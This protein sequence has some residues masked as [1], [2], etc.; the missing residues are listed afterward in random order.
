MDSFVARS[1]NK[2]MYEHAKSI[3]CPSELW[4]RSLDS[5]INPCNYHYWGEAKYST[6]LGSST[7]SSFHETPRQDVLIRFETQ[8][9]WSS[10]LGG[11][12]AGVL[13]LCR[14][15]A[16]TGLTGFDV[17]SQLLEISQVLDLVF[18]QFRL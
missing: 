1:H 6:T 5:V 18:W 4:Q 2:F 17:G 10:G 13:S 14:I 9:K 16:L 7:N 12:L 8:H 3:S 11:L 15:L